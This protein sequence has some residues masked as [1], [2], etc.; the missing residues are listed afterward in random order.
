MEVFY[1][2]ENSSRN[3]P[4]A[5]I[6]PEERIILRIGAGQAITKSARGSETNFGNPALFGKLLFLPLQREI[7]RDFGEYHCT[8]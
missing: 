5:R 1:I 4:S 7:K 3:S 6:E 2:L 8:L